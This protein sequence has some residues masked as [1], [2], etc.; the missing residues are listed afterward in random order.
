MTHQKQSAPCGNT[1]AP[2]SQLCT[3]IVADKA[4]RDQD[5]D[6][7]LDRIVR[8][9]DTRR[10]TIQRLPHGE[11]IASQGQWCRLLESREALQRFARLVGV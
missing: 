3:E 10:I 9:F 2:Q 5:H 4:H 8:R 6:D 11:F 1:G 7:D